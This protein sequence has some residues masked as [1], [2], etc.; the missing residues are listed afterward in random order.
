MGRATAH[1]TVARREKALISILASHRRALLN[2]HPTA[3]WVN[4]SFFVR[5]LIGGYEA[6]L[7]A[8]RDAITSL[9]VDHLQMQTSSRLPS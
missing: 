2:V 8:A 1:P 7:Q 9:S 5:S 4:E 3:E 6:L